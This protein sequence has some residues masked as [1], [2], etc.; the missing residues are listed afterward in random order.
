[1]SS[2]NI[3]YRLFGNK[4]KAFYSIA[5]IL[6]VIWICLYNTLNI[7]DYFQYF[8][9]DYFENKYSHHVMLL[10]EENDNDSYTTHLCDP[11]FSN[12]TQYSVTIDNVKY[13]RSVLLHANRSIN[14][15]CL[16]KSKQIKRILFWTQPNWYGDDGLGRVTPFQNQNCPVT[17]CELTSDQTKL[18]QSDLVIVHMRD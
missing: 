13:P 12:Y 5:V 1:M 6:L 4:K 7:D 18:Y 17:N 2:K 9:G 10:D 8:P 16:R 3:L 14:F 15:E 11:I